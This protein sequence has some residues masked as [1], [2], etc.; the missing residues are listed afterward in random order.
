[1]IPV[2]T[3]APPE[4]RWAAFRL[5]FARLVYTLGD[6]LCYLG[7]RLA[8][9]RIADAGWCEGYGRCRECGCTDH[10]ACIDDFAPCYW[11]E[12]DLCSACKEKLDGTGG[13]GF[14]R[15]ALGGAS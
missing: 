2:L 6:R 15:S 1:M 10:A 13:E 14:F 9:A 5:W 4:G 12:P 11:V 8:P 7:S 3:P